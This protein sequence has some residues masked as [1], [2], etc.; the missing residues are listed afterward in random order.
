MRQLLQP[1]LDW[2][3][4]I[5][6]KMKASLDATPLSGT[7]PILCVFLA[8][9]GLH[10]DSVETV[11]IDKDGAFTTGKAAT[12]GV[13]IIFTRPG[14]KPQ[15]LYYLTTDLS[16]DAI[17]SNPGFLRFCEAQ[18][19]GAN[20]LKAPSYLL[21]D[22]GFDRVREF[23]LKSS[24]VLVQDDS[25]IPVHHL[26]PARWDVRLFGVYQSPIE[27]FKQHLQ[28]DLAGMYRSGKPPAFEKMTRLHS[29]QE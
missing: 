21:H 9:L 19:R 22:G 5:T 20:L 7:M 27:I 8:R 13:K 18:G 29:S 24:T 16:D 23:I 2:S 3:F 6:E 15:T 10:I 25:G 11:A 17:K 14:G 28:P 1:S 26:D 12:P 4:F